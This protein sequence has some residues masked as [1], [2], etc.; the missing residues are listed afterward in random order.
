MDDGAVIVLA[1]LLI[2]ASLIAA[3]VFAV[4][5]LSWLV[6]ELRKRRRRKRLHRPEQNDP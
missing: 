5:A 6:D 4:L 1:Y 3:F 2:S